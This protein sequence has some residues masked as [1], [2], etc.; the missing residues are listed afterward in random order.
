MRGLKHAI[1]GVV[2]FKAVEWAIHVDVRGLPLSSLPSPVSLLPS[3]P[4]VTDS[5]VGF[6]HE[7]K[8]WRRD[9]LI[10]EL[11]TGTSKPEEPQPKTP[12]V[13]GRKSFTFDE[14]AM[15]AY[16]RDVLQWWRGERPPRGVNVEHSHRCL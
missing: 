1:G 15:Q 8:G 6:G 2:H 4:S 12:G 7:C 16:V 14:A 13:I 3:S 5:L 11:G 10:Y 9:Q